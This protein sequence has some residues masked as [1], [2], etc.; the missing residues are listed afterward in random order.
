MNK[1]I[2]SAILAFLLLISIQLLAKKLNKTD[3]E[4]L[5]QSQRN[6]IQFIY[7]ERKLNNLISKEDYLGG[8]TI[9]RIFVSSGYLD[10]TK[11]RVLELYGYLT[12]F[13]E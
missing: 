11:K 6:L 12:R 9:Q 3:N 2:K 4:I 13:V 7:T 8:G 1:H 5:K 10:I